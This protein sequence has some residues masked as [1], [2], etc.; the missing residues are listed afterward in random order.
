[1]SWESRAREGRGQGNLKSTS[2]STPNGAP[3]ANDSM[4]LSL[5]F[6]V[7]GTEVKTGLAS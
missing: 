4:P 2:G 1:M 3:W 7:C 6:F 5:S